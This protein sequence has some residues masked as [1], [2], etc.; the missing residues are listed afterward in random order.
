[1]DPRTAID[2]DPALSVLRDASV[3]VARAE[4]ERVVAMQRY[5][6]A[7]LRRI[8][9]LDSPMRRMVE[10]AGIPVEIGA[11]TGFSEGQVVGLLA[12]ADRVR[13]QAPSVWQAF[14]DGRV[15]QARLREVA[16]TL[17]RLARPE[18][19]A[20][21]DGLAVGYATTHT[22]AELRRWLR[23]FVARTEPDLATERAEVER[24]RRHVQVH[25]VD[26]SMAWL[27]AYLPA[28]QAAAIASRLRRRV[29]R[30]RREGD[31]RTLE[32]LR[33]DLL[34]DAAMGADPA[35]PASDPV[36]DVAVV[37]DAETLDAGNPAH[38]E[39][40]D[41]AWTV[42]FAWVLE[43]AAQGDSFWHRLLVD[44]VTGGTYDHEYSGYAPPEL[45]RRAIVLRDGVCVTPGCVTPAAECDLDHV[46]PWPRGRTV[47]T[48]L[49]PR[50]RRHHALKGHG[51]LARP[52][53]PGV[54][55][56]LPPPGDRAA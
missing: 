7:E 1:M 36:I 25:Q 51:A 45:L 22:T 6:D 28:H 29:R 3:A 17:G 42:P 49:R 43:A 11:A 10:Q 37:V 38:A 27:T 5:R 30:M 53:E 8:G 41:G 16:L 20:R 52:D 24:D 18:S 32:Q 44:P 15:D 47:G 23:R 55:H 12:A 54:E 21:L 13:D 14:R 26:D 4:A 31:S 9:G 48:N 35:A 39:S 56:G 46:E 19:W 2:D 34:A 40:A 50:C 33:A